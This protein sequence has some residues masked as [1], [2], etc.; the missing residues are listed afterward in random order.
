MK[1]RITINIIQK[2]IIQ[3]F[4]NLHVYITTEQKPKGYVV[5][6]NKIVEYD[7]IR[8]LKI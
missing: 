3:R 1:S 8:K 2:I 7:Y 5:L 4:P 6:G